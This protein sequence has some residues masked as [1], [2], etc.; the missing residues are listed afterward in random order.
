MPPM[1][2][3][4]CFSFLATDSGMQALYDATH[5]PRLVSGG[6]VFLFSSFSHDD[7]DQQAL[8]P[9]FVAHYRDRLGIPTSNFLFVLHSGSSNRTGLAQLRQMLNEKYDV[10]HTFPVVGA[11]TSELILEHKLQI[12]LKYVQGRDWVV[13]ADG[14]EFVMLPSWRTAYQAFDHLDALDVNVQFGVMVDRLTADGNMDTSPPER[15]SLFA[16]FP[17]SCCMTSM[18]QQSDVRKT[19]SYRGYLRT[20]SGNHAVLGF[21]ET[22]MRLTERSAAGRQSQ[23]RRLL[24]RLREQLGGRLF[25]LLPDTYGDRLPLVR[26]SW[27]FS[28]V[29]HFKWIKGIRQKLRRRTQTGGEEWERGHQALYHHLFDFLEYGISTL[30]LHLLCPNRQELPGPTEPVRPLYARELFQLASPN[31]SKSG[32]HKKLAEDGDWLAS[33]SITRGDHVRGEESIISEAL[34]LYSPIEHH[35]REQDVAG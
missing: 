20:G 30:E 4:P 10:P 29:Y 11:F 6:D 12:L 9:H 26:R 32:N 33:Y 5:T 3:E 8:I 35:D 1:T 7:E 14:D 18:V 15:G 17:M 27:S 28:T 19:S 21:N 22:A 16:Q 31:V 13:E 34:I 23:Q 25:G 24:R 2:P